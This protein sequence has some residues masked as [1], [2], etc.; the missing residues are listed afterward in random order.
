MFSGKLL[1]IL[2]PEYYTPFCAFVRFVVGR[3]K[4]R[5]CLVLILC[6]AELNLKVSVLKWKNN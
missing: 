2:I 5:P 6:I 4:S 3:C 1:K